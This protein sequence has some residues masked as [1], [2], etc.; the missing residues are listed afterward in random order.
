MKKFDTILCNP[1]Y[2]TGEK[3]DVPLYPLFL[4][5][6]HKNPNSVWVIPSSWL[7]NPVWSIGSKI[8]KQFHK[9]GLFHVYK[10]QDDVFVTARV[11]TCSCICVQGY[12]GNFVWESREEQKSLVK[13][14]KDLLNSKIHFSFDE[15]EIQFLNRMATYSRGPIKWFDGKPETWKIGVFHI[16]RDKSKDQLGGIRLM[17]PNEFEGKHS[18]KYTKLWEGTSESEANEMLPRIESY[19][20]SSLLQYLLAKVWHTYTI[21]SSMFSLLPHPDYSRIWSDE[22]IL[23]FYQVTEQER[24]IINR[25]YNKT[26]GKSPC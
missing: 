3:N 12:R 24:N 26:I 21:Q 20:Q 19:W 17:D 15:D 6:F 2:N 8:R 23:D 14:E 4:E 25:Y 22:E 10:N 5:K 11:R 1:P 13:G 7:G 18:V 9:A 16:N